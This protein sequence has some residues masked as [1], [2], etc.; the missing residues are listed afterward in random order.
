MQPRITRLGS[1]SERAERV[2]LYVFSPTALGNR[3]GVLSV[4]AFGSPHTVNLSGTAVAP[5]LGLGVPLGGTSMATV[6]A[7]NPQP[8]C[9]LSAAAG[10]AGSP[11]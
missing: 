3:T 5:S 4:V 11:R 6:S 8:T 2:L 10:L 9:S 1:G 7:G